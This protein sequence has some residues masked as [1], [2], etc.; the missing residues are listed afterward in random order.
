M[1][2]LEHKVNEIL[3]D[4]AIEIAKLDTKLDSIQED[5]KAIKDAEKRINNLESQNAYLKGMG[6]MLLIFAPIGSAILT[7]IAGKLF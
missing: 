5:I 4:L 6:A 1:K 3:M 7:H 2:N